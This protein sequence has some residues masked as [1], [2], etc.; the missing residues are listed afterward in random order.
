MSA[1]HKL[2]KQARRATFEDAKRTFREVDGIAGNFGY[3]TGLLGSTLLRGSGIDIDL[4]VVPSVDTKK[5]TDVVATEIITGLAK[6]IY[7]YEEL[8]EDGQD[9]AMTFLSYDR[10]MVD[11]Y[12]VGLSE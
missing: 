1:D 10:T 6:V 3:I 8:D 4:L 9:I 11:V 2:P 12:L 7:S 5:T